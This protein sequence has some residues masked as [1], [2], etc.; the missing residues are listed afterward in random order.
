MK[1][2][3]AGIRSIVDL[4]YKVGSCISYLMDD[5]VKVEDSKGMANIFNNVFLNTANK[6]NEKISGT[7]KSPLDLMTQRSL[8][9]FLFLQSYLLKFKIS[10]TLLNLV[11]LLVLS[12]FQ[13]LFSSY[14]VNI[15]PFLC[16]KL[17]M[18][19]S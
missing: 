2:L 13:Y 6:I 5:N 3:W 10:L 19:L 18:N 7:R 9:S 1:Q 15:Y 11:K 12:A 17:S 16:V 14:Y 4:K 8:N